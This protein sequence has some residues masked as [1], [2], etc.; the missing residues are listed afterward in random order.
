LIVHLCTSIDFNM[1]TAAPCRFR[2]LSWSDEGMC[3]CTAFVPGRCPFSCEANNQQVDALYC[4]EC[5]DIPLLCLN[6][7]HDSVEH[8]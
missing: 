5:A 1:N 3:I 8:G 6:C 7:P 2:P 4:Y